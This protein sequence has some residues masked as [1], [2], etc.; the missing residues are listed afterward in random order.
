MG[1]CA[2]AGVA[3]IAV[4]IAAAH[5]AVI[6]VLFNMSFLLVVGRKLQ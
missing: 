5:T 3:D 6:N 2:R 1:P 4:T